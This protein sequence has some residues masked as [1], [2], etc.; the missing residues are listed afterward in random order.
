MKIIDNIKDIKSEIKALKLS[1]KSIGFVPTMG[2]LHDGH[3]SLANESVA[4]NDITIV[5]IFV[6]PTQFGVNEDY[7][8]Y[9]RDLE[10]DCSL[11]QSANVDIVFNPS[12]DEMYGSKSLT[13]VVVDVMSSKLCGISRPTHFQGVTTVVTKL[14]NIV[15]PDNAYFGSKDLQ[16]VMIIKKMVADLNMNVN[17]VSMPIIRES[18]GLALSSRNIYLTDDERVQALSLNQSLK[19]AKQMFDNNTTFAKDVYDA[20]HTKISE[21][22]L[23]TI[24]YIS[25]VDVETLEA[26]ETVSKGTAI[27]LAVKF[28]R[29]RLIDNIVL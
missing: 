10:R 1:G 4:N 14:F 17:I 11:L 21:N 6:N 16:Q 13:S 25:I 3:L 5:S 24:D 23:A 8:S 26:V 18:D 28:G 22:N 20:I 9:P 12:P 27:L 7:G 29:A 2:Y 15:T 19:L